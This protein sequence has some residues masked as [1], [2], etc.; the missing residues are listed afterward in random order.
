MKTNKYNAMIESFECDFSLAVTNNRSLSDLDALI[1]KNNK[2]L[3]KDIELLEELSF[4]LRHG[5]IEIHNVERS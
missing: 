4:G 2:K 3:I 1:V 5:T